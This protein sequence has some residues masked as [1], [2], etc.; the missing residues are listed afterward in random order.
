MADFTLDL[1]CLQHALMVLV[2]NM[3][4][5]DVFG[6][7]WC[8]ILGGFPCCTIPFFEKHNVEVRFRTGSLVTQFG[9]VLTFVS[10]FRLCCLDVDGWIASYCSGQHQ[11][12][13]WGKGTVW[14]VV[15]LCC[16]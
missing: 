12:Y 11:I 6:W 10:T 13:L 16:W 15:R 3:S 1:Y 2:Q 5:P 14:V 8:N 4:D 9:Y 7:T